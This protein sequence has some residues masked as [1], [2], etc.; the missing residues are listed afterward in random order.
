MTQ[1]RVETLQPK[2]NVFILGKELCQTV[3]ILIHRI[4]SIQNGTD[5]ND[6]NMK[7]NEFI[8]GFRNTGSEM[9]RFIVNM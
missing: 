4:S 5:P 6:S 8:S 1:I 2:P 3:I 7:E 9:L